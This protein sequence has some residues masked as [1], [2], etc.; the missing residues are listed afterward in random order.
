MKTN[1]K[2]DPKTE[3]CE[4]IQSNPSSYSFKFTRNEFVVF[5]LNVIKE[6]LFLSIK[7]FLTSSRKELAWSTFNNRIPAV[8]KKKTGVVFCF[9]IGTGH[10]C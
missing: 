5:G 10:L 6:H 8:A 4:K 3:C 1:S 9:F 2:K 7:S